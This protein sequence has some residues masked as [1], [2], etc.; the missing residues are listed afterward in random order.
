MVRAEHKE[1][2]RN[3]IKMNLYPADS[4]FHD[5]MIDLIT[6]IADSVNNNN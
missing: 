6:V 5:N 4:H 3:N 1:E 2:I